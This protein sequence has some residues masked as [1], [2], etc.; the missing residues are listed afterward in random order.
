M[1][2]MDEIKENAKQTDATL[3]LCPKCNGQGLVSKPPHIA[4]DVDSWISDQATYICNLC[5]GKMVVN[6][7]LINP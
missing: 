3:I 1:E 5:N 2:E 6:P 7:S 4:V